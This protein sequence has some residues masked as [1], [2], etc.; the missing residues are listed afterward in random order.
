ML[1]AFK[2][3]IKNPVIRA[4]LL[5]L[6]VYLLTGLGFSAGSLYCYNWR[7]WDTF[8]GFSL[9][10]LFAIGFFFDLFLWP[11]YLRANLINSLGVFGICA[12][13]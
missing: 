4:L 7:N 12:L 6:T 1:V 9:P 3:R 2:Q 5:G 10:P 13:P 8:G 11:V